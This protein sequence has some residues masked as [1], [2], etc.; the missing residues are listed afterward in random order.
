MPVRILITGSSGRIGSALARE[1]EG[2]HEL[3][4]VDVR[5][6]AAEAPTTK[7]H[8]LLGDLEDEEVCRSAVEGAD[9]IAHLGANPGAFMPRT[10]QRNTLSAWNLC[11]AAR[12]A[13]VQRIAFASTINVWGQGQFKIG[14]TERIPPRLPIDET[15]H[16]YPE[17]SYGLSKLANE[18]V[19]RG[20]ADGHGIKSF[21]FRLAGVWSQ[22]WIDKYQPEPLS[23]LPLD[24]SHIIDPWHY[25]DMRDVVSAFRL[26]LEAPDAPL[27]GVSYLV[28]DD[29]TRPELTVD[30]F[31]SACRSGCRWVRT[32]CK[33]MRRG[34]PRRA[35]RPSWGGN[36]V[37]AGVLLGCPAAE[38][39]A[40]KRSLAAQAVA[41]RPRR[42]PW[43]GCRGF[44]R[45]VDWR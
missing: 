23:Q 15:M 22:R 36:P 3:T 38:A 8:F 37:I 45:R 32:N 44:S 26:A 7:H 18:Q 25:I 33:V 41:L 13:G 21:C 9:A 35:L 40:T 17:G 6:P 2:E 29:T 5:P 34:F 16:C 30:L 27:F 4:L 31:D 10:Y 12:E 20:F 14:K 11:N 28:A 19:L 24:A 43:C 39:A 1:L 42:W